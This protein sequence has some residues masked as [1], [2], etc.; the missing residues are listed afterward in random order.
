MLHGSIFLIGSDFLSAFQATQTMYP[1]DKLIQYIKDVLFSLQR[2]GKNMFYWIPR[3]KG[4]KANEEEGI[5]TKAACLKKCV[6][7]FTIPKQ[8][9]LNSLK[10]GILNE[11]NNEWLTL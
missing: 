8:G 11:W 7:F 3:H 10:I 1:A 6:D 9:V 2:D 4:I 5:S